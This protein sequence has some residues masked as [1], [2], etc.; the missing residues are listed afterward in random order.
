MAAAISFTTSNHGKKI[1]IQSGYVYRLRKT[2]SKVKYWTCEAKA[3]M[4]NVH[5]DLHD[6]FIKS[7]GD[8]HHLPSLEQVEIRNFK[9]KV[10]ER[11]Q[12]ETTAV[13]FIYDEELAR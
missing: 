11:V 2:T 8:H 13:P 9:N 4:A 10:K 3:S 5:T 6:I 1:L 12:V 7:N